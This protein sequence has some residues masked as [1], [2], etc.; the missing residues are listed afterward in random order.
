MLMVVVSS[1][2]DCCLVSDKEM[3][4]FDVFELVL[5]LVFLV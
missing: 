1:S 4:E 3:D 5:Q 2:N